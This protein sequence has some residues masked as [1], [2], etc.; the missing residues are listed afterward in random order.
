LGHTVK[1]IYPVLVGY[2]C[3]EQFIED[4]AG[5]TLKHINISVLKG[6]EI[7][8]EEFGDAMFTHDGIS[9]PIILELSQYTYDMYDD[10]F[11]ISIDLKPRVPFEELDARVNKL[12]RDNGKASLKNILRDLLPSSLIETFIEAIEFDPYITGAKIDKD[13]RTVLVSTLK[14]FRLNVVDSEGYKRAVVNTGGVEIKEIDPM[15]MK[16]KLINNLYL[17]GDIIDVFGPTG[18]FNLQI[19]WS[20]AFTAIKDLEK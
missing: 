8:K 9:G 14:D 20:T 13:M 19:C 1:P 12:L 10:G 7:F 11:E 18:G 17:I 16:S 2:K 3:K 5:L 15:T 6:G 4:L